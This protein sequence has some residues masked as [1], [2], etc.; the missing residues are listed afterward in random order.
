M[1]MRW[2][3]MKRKPALSALTALALCLIGLLAGCGGGAGDDF[4]GG[5]T[6]ISDATPVV[7][8]GWKI[9]T[10]TMYH[11]SLEYPANWFP[12]D[13]SGTAD[14]LS[15]YNYDP[16][17]VSDPEEVPPPP[18]NKLEIDAFTN[19]NKLSLTDFYTVFRETDPDSPPAS[20]Q[21]ARTL[22]IGDH[23]AL[24][25]TQLPVEWTDGKIDFASVAYYVASGDDVL[26]VKEEYSTGGQPSPT[27]THVVTS[28]KF[29]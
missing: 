28:L 24:Q 8:A 26:I 4:G 14:Y 22:T 9:Y 5:D 11:Y 16:Q 3:D 21:E 13:T 15:I 12:D 1:R 17:K 19:P 20:S 25:V 7:A 23:Q 29:T 27:L 18:Y 6:S 2:G 10:N